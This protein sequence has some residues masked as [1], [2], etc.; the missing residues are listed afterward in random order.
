MG[1][2]TC[3][4]AFVSPC[5]AFVLSRGPGGIL[6]SKHGR[7]VPMAAQ[8]HRHNHRSH[9]RRCRPGG[10]SHRRAD[11]VAGVRNRCGDGPVYRITKL[12][13]VGTPCLLRRIPAAADAGWRHGVVQYDENSVSF[14]RLSSCVWA[15]RRRCC[16]RPRRSVRADDR[17]AARRIFSTVWW[18]SSSN[19][20]R[21][22][23]AAPTS[24]RCPRGGHRVPVVD[25]GPAVGAFATTQ[26]LQKND[27]RRTAP[28]LEHGQ[29]RIRSPP[30]T[31]FTSPSPCGGWAATG[32]G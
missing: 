25:R 6:Y 15:R 11:R 21:T 8:H 28:R 5:E 20:A 17:S 30:G 31:H 10:F 12:R 23:T 29:G 4:C 27:A 18:C 32:P 7:S 22:G 1:R 16:G 24:W 9:T 19:P 3:G 2:A 13:S 26:S 14:Y